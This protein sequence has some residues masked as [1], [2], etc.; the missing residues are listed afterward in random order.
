[1]NSLIELAKQ[2]LDQSAE[3]EEFAKQDRWEE[4]TKLQETHTKIVAKIMITE[5]EESIKTELRTLLIEVRSTNNRT[6][7]LANAHKK[8]LISKKKTLGKAATMQKTLDAL[9]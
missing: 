5:A 4:L 2:A 7:E 8:S 3:M 1:M 6:M 9:K